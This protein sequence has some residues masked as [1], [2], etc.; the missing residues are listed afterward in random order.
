LELEEIPAAG[1]AGAVGEGGMAALVGEEAELGMTAEVVLPREP[2][3]AL[4]V[5]LE[6][7]VVEG[8]GAGEFERAV[9][10]FDE[11]TVGEQ[12][13]DIEGGSGIDHDGFGRIV[14]HAEQAVNGGGG[15]VAGGD[16]ADDIEAVGV[17]AGFFA[18]MVPPLRV[19]LA[20]VSLCPRRFQ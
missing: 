1:N 16:H 4:T 3:G 12:G 5:E 14:V 2:E 10:G 7:A 9:A 18:S 17:A 15:G 20:M 8:V 13:V 6:G 11:A 19:R